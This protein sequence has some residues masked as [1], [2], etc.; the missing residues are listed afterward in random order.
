MSNHS[1][2][3]VIKL[4]YK[5]IKLMKSPSIGRKRVPGIVLLLLSKLRWQPM[6]LDL[7]MKTK[8]G[9]TVNEVLKLNLAKDVTA[10]AAKIISEWSQLLPKRIGTI[11]PKELIGQPLKSVDNLSTNNSNTNTINKMSNEKMVKLSA[12]VTDNKENKENKRLTLKPK[13]KKSV[14]LMTST[15]KSDAVIS[16]HEL[17]ES[18]INKKKERNGKQLS[19]KG[20]GA[21]SPWAMTTKTK[22]DAKVRHKR[23]QK[24]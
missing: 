5:L 24:C 7:L 12:D 8:V 3:E 19:G 16:G 22:T 9:V 11:K 21:P 20:V 14:K 1:E 23:F 2:T 4:N 15:P 17:Y 6:T 10:F 13:L 18:I